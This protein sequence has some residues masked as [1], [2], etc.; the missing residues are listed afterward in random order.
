MEDNFVSGLYVF[1]PSERAASFVKAKLS[2]KPEQMIEW[3][4]TAKAN[5][6]GFV[7]IDIL[8][9]KD[10]KKWYAKK[11][12]YVRKEVAESVVGANED[13]SPEDIPF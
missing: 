7:S 11:D 5:E 10:G 13:I 3:L 9:S 4:K 1:A 8:E 2:V 6:K 12:E